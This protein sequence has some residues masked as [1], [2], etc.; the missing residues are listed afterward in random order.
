[1]P[2]A[3]ETLAETGVATRLVQDKTPVRTLMVKVVAGASRGLRIAL[4]SRPLVIGADD[5]VDLVVDDPKVSRR[6]LEL[7]AVPGGVAIRDLGSTNGVF[8]DSAR[9]NDATFP[10]GTIVRLG[11]TALE[12]AS[13][14]APTVPP[15]D[16]DRFGGL[17]GVSLAM[18][19]VFA[20]LELAA[21]TVATVLIQGESGTGKELAARALH[22]HSPRAEKPFVVVDCGS[23]PEQLIESQLF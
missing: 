7:R 2:A 10:A 16:R 19:E 8:V 20:V 17:V 22:D 23:A 12:D 21:P 3:R 4:S 18:R 15:S 1:M 11:D 14:P 9:I 6:H 5:D 13:A